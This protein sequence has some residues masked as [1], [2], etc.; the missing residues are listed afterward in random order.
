MLV[1]IVYSYSGSY[2]GGKERFFTTPTT[3]AW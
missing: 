1:V 3:A 2:R